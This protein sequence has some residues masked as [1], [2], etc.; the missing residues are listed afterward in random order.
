M[1]GALI[2]EFAFVRGN[3]PS[4]F[5]TMDVRTAKTITVVVIEG[6]YESMRTGVTQRDMRYVSWDH[7]G[8]DDAQRPTEHRVPVG[9]QPGELQVTHSLGLGQCQ[10]R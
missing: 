6:A 4:D 8:P 9:G 5:T 10:C 1:S 7:S 3:R 2:K